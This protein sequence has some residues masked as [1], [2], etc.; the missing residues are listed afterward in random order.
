MTTQPATNLWRKIAQYIAAANSQTALR[1]GSPGTYLRE[2][3]ITTEEATYLLELHFL[4]TEALSIIEQGCEIMTLDQLGTWKGVR[5]FLERV[6]EL[7]EEN[8]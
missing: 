3:M 5:G 8:A 6:H 7:Y 1:Q 2:N 4:L